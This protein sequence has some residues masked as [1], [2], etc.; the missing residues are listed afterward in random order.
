M[1]AKNSM[2]QGYEY[3][4]I[5]CYIAASMIFNNAQRPG[6]V[7]HMTI[8]EYKQREYIDDKV[9]I[10]V[11]NHKTSTSQG[12]ASIVITTELEEM[13]NQYLTYVRKT[14]VANTDE[15]KDNLF[16]TITG[17]EFKK[18]CETI[19]LVASK[20]DLSTPSPSVH[21]KVIA[22][23]G[24]KYLDEGG[25]RSLASHMSHSETTSR[26]FYQFPSEHEA[27]EVHNTIKH[28][29]ARRCFSEKEDWSLLKEYSLNNDTTPT[30][31]VCK[32]IVKKYELN[33]SAKQLQ[34]RWRTLK[35]HSKQ[36]NV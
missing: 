11:L 12:P 30:L 25:M 32:L 5:I 13:I 16:L 33:R 31:E 26:K 21:R 22:S 15:L 34:D 4:L 28:L 18:I 29:N 24:R 6:V 3:K 9:V 35:N 8:S 19:Q 10:T 20:F 7:R 14:I 17:N 1:Q 36:D 27:Y 2:L 23:E